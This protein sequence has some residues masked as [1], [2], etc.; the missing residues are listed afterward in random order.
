MRNFI[1]T[2]SVE[3]EAQRREAKEK[4]AAAKEKVFL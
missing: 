1:E 3:S 2:K 4:A